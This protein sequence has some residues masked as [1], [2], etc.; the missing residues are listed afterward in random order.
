MSSAS[1]SSAAEQHHVPFAYW[2]RMVVIFFF[3][4][5]VL[6]AGR[7]VF[8]PVVGEIQAEF[9]LNKAQ[10][11]GIM[12]LFFLAYTALQV[13]SGILGDKIGRKNVLV[14][15]LAI[16][17]LSIAAVWFAPTYSIFIILWMLA[18]AAQGSYYGP[19]Y[20]I[21]TEA[22]PKKW[23]TLGSA[24]IGSGM[25]F[26]IA[27]GL[28]LSSN[29]VASPDAG[30]YGTSW[31]A[32]FVGIAIIIAI[33]TLLVAFLIRE[34]TLPEE[35]VAEGEK[36]KTISVNDFLDLFKNRNLVLAY[37]TIFCSIYGFFVIMTWLPNYLESE[38]GISKTTASNLTSLVAWLS[39]IGTVFFSYLSDKLGKRRPIILFMMP[40]SML[41][42][43]SIAWVHDYYA[44]VAIL[45]LYG[46]VGKIS[47]NPVLIAVVADNVPRT[48][49]S[50]AF[51]LYN[52]FG[53]AASIGAPV[54]TGMITDRTGSM[55]N[56]FYF[57]AFVVLIGIIAISFL[58]EEQSSDSKTS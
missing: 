10:V 9:D 35:K 14:S 3:G 54:I 19:Q 46:F 25:S 33:V 4:W 16:Y 7:M 56:A 36:K 32:P 50:S 24:I 29:M 12:S 8:S 48:S 20:A 2:A 55:D 6:Y 18:G 26:G 11:G 53:M 41:A 34:K 51:G 58:K 45:I 44:I 47:L 21:S 5:V 13:P 15:G 31:R 40:L 1:S 49:L 42:I 37:I 27:L 22:I 28:S 38:R 57:A 52:F 39:I 23:I 43:M 17:T 30:G